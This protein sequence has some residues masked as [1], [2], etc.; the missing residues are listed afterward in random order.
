MQLKESACEENFIHE[1]KVAEARKTLVQGDDGEELARTFGALADPTRVRI[2]SALLETELCVCDISALLKVSQS[3]I[4]H[5]LRQL[6]DMRLV[7]S[8]KE[9]RIVY[10]TLDDEHISELFLLGSEHLRHK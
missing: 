10:Y 8:R 3:A 7:R 9:G 4:S 5:Q 2:I 6:R 1:A